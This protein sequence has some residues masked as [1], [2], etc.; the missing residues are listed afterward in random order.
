[1]LFYYLGV[2]VT[3]PLALLMVL[4]QVNNI[5]IFTNVNMESKKLKSHLKWKFWALFLAF[6]TDRGS[7]LY[8]G[9]QSLVVSSAIVK[10]W[11]TSWKNDEG[12][13]CILFILHERLVLFHSL[14]IYWSCRTVL[15]MNEAFVLMSI[16]QK[17]WSWCF[18]ACFC[19]FQN[20]GGWCINK[21]YQWTAVFI[22][23]WEL[24]QFLVWQDGIRRSKG[25]NC[26][27]NWI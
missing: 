10:R 14:V 20:V 7:I 6:T 1:M 19:W 16:I 5:T 27:C 11:P 26:S 9:K 18:L 4:K 2:D 23:N 25:C 17:I 3:F 22:G 21:I 12:L 15:C 8:E 24:H 13:D